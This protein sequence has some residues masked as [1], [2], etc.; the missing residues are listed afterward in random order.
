MEVKTL[1]CGQWKDGILS[2]G[3]NNSGDEIVYDFNGHDFHMS[4]VLQV[5]M[6]NGNKLE[7]H[8]EVFVRKVMETAEEQYVRVSIAHWEEYRK[9]FM[10]GETAHVIPIH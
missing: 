6:L 2:I 4:N 9:D 7:D 8:K 3:M 10:R 1:W 5:Q